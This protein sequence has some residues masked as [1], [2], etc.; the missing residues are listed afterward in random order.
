[1]VKI[2]FRREAISNNYFV[3]LPVRYISQACYA[4]LACS[5]LF[6]WSFLYS[7]I[8]YGSIEKNKTVLKKSRS[9]LM[10]HFPPQFGKMCSDFMDK[11]GDSIY[12]SLKKHLD[13][14]TVS[15]QMFN[16]LERN[17]LYSPL[18]PS[19]RTARSVSAYYSAEN[20]VLRPFLFFS[21]P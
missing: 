17:C 16:I 2:L 4:I 3:C 1:M 6:S 10:I 13:D 15:L 9:L 5:Y 14:K 12:D 8:A 7:H 19:V 21:S 11:Y 18:C 20:L